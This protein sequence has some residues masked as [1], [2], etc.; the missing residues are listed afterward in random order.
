MELA[1]TEVIER[2]ILVT[3]SFLLKTGTAGVFLLL[4]QPGGLSLHPSARWVP[5]QRALAPIDLGSGS[6]RSPLPASDRRGWREMEEK[7]V[8]IIYNASLI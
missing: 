3:S 5:C 2:S 1:F 4:I 6:S 7:I 8:D